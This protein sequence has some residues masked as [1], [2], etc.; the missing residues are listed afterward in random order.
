MTRQLLMT[1]LFATAMHGSVVA[2]PNQVSVTTEGKAEHASQSLT[3]VVDNYPPYID[4]QMPGQGVLTE[5]VVAALQ[6]Q[7]ISSKLQFSTWQHIRQA[8][9]EPHY[10]SFLWFKDKELEQDW[11][12]SE[13]IVELRQVFI[14]TAALTFEPERL[15]QLREYRLGLT[16]GHFYGA[17]FEAQKSTFRL[18]TVVSDYQN[19]QQLLQGQVDFIL[20]DPIVAHQLVQSL[21]QQTVKLRYL[22]K[23]L[24]TAKPAYLVC[25]RNYLPCHGI[26]QQFNRGLALQQQN[27]LER[28]LFGFGVTLLP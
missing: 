11:L 25:S 24:L 14:S 7:G 19:L 22:S 13:P 12:F 18:S 21:P 2:M 4:E 20:M 15:D 6:S 8:A 5:L 17:Q 28:R 10:A 9:A 16:D 23:P 1:A 27:G 3:L 26:I